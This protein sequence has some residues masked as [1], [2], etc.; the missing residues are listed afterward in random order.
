VLV[1]RPDRTGRVQ[2]L[3]VHLK[4]VRLGADVN[5]EEIAALTPGFS[6]ADLAN[7]VNEAALLATRRR[8]DAVE[9]QDFNA[10]IERIIAGLEKKNRLLNP[11][12]RR[13][14][15]YHEMG[16]A[17]VATALPGSDPVHKISIIPR[18]VGALGYTIQRPTEDRFLMT[19]AEL[20]NKMAVLLG[21]RAAEHIVFNHLST[22][23][24]DDL[25]KVTDIARSMIMRYGMDTTLGHVAYEAER[26][27]YLAE[28]SGAGTERSYSEETAREIDK[29]VRGIIHSAFQRAVDLLA[30]RRAILEAGA[31]QLLAKE[32]I[33][34]KELKQLLQAAPA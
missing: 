20:E 17:L 33:T 22:G 14:V 18:G 11:H 2:I 7:L 25:Q 30:E 4:K 34:E 8:A 32:T 23:A 28:M 27:T 19:R 9:M 15:A 29:A 16:H 5:A 10:G 12:E 1:D 13:V 21:G 6:G 24:A 3:Q 31:E 26:R